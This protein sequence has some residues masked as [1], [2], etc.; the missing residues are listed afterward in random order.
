MQFV[1]FVD[2]RQGRINQYKDYI[3]GQTQENG[4]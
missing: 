3:Y 2:F 4:G 1:E